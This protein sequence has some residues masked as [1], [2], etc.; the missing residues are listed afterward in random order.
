[1]GTVP[2]AAIA[3]AGLAGRL[4]AWQLARRGWRVSLFDA[5]LRGD[6]G[7]ASGV[8]AAMLSPLAERVGAD[9][10]VFTLAQRSMDLWPRWLDHLHHDCGHAVYFR[11][12]G[13]LV[14]A[15]EA[16]AG[17][18]AQFERVL[19]HKLPPAHAAQVRVLEGE[20]LAAAEPGLAGRFARGLLLE[21]EGQLAN[22]ELLAALDQALARHGVEWHEGV[23]VV[24]L[25]ASQVHSTLGAHA[26][27]VVIDTRGIGAQADCPG[28]R[29]VRGELL[30]VA[31]EAV[32]LKRPVRL[33]HPR[34]PL[35][36]AP[37]PQQRFVVGATELESQD[38]GPVALRS[39]LELGSALYSLNPAFAEARVLRLAAALRPA[40]DD[41]RPVLRHHDGV[42]Q[43]NGLY[44]H[45]YLCAPAL[46][47]RL[48]E[49]LTR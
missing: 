22:D 35:Y 12:E 24:L 28:L 46:V 32:Q 14:V 29:G 33:L 34:H 3:G 25:D 30:T 13:T 5:R 48:V 16:D 47:D 40:F 43:L 26:A 18:L 49:T 4:V 27:E 37:R 38:E 21:G 17:E 19:R 10:E 11:R 45:G 41:H 6:P 44:R 39:M 15:H 23:Q 36:I 42:W 7:A 2:H 31:C 20:A 1:V 8:A 9:E